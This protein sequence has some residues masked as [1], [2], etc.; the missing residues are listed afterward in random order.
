MTFRENGCKSQ[1]LLCVRSLSGSCRPS[2]PSL[3]LR[4]QTGAYSGRFALEHD[5][6]SRRYSTLANLTN[7]TYLS[8]IRHI[9][10]HAIYQP[11][12]SI[13][14]SRHLGT[15]LRLVTHPNIASPTHRHVQRIIVL[16]IIAV[17]DRR[18]YSTWA[19]IGST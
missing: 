15:V 18:I 11:P 4:C 12:I 17:K 2:L 8:Q 19:R 16:F 1:S 10:L 14:N 13:S 7:S 9:Y 3:R 5:L 6:G